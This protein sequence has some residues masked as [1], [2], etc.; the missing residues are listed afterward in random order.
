MGVYRADTQTQQLR[1][2]ALVEGV[3]ATGLQ[4]MRRYHSIRLNSGSLVFS[5]CVLTV[6]GCAAP[7]VGP[8]TSAQA[9]SWSASV[10]LDDPAAVTAA[11]SAQHADWNGIRY[12]EGGV[13]RDGVDCSGF[14]L[15]TYVNRF[16]VSLPRTVEQQARL[17]VTVSQHALHAGDLVFFKTGFKTR[18]VGIYLGDRQ[19][20]HA[21]TSQGVTLSSLDNPYWRAKFWQARRLNI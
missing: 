11:L 3:L 13:G 2:P 18:H 14:T 12:K 10:S 5:L 7:E 6:A 4:P 15:V 17:G 16:G 8:Q 20:L 19:F 1:R 21:S 9:S